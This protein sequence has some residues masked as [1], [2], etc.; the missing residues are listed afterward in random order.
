MY[1]VVNQL[2]Q[3]ALDLEDILTENV[4]AIILLY[5][6]VCLSQTS[7]VIE[8]TNCKLVTFRCSPNLLLVIIFNWITVGCTLTTR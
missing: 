5:R 7:A 6:T 1:I 3:P 4:Q 2:S 8:S